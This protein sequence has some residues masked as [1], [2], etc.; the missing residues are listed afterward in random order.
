MENTYS[1]YETKSHLS[2]LLKRVKNGQEL[3]VT[4]RGE[5]IARVIPYQKKQ[6]LNARI[7][8]LKNHGII[9]KRRAKN[10]AF[11]AGEKRRGALKRFLTE[12]E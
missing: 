3:I 4:E 9:M 1:I 8:E 11:P 6:T 5:P 2:R 7:Q 10:L 12:R